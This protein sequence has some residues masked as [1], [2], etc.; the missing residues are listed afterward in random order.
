MNIDRYEIIST[1]VQTFVVYYITYRTTLRE[2][3][4]RE[5]FLA[6]LVDSLEVAR[7]LAEAEKSQESAG[8]LRQIISLIRIN[9]AKPLATKSRT[10]EI[11]NKIPRRNWFSCRK[12]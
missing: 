7:A 1:V 4:R 9:Y 8:V 11:Q 5:N 10:G 3:K 6:K 2:V 12:A